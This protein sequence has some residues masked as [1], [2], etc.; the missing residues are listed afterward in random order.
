M[1]FIIIILSNDTDA[2][3]YQQDIAK[4]PCT[5]TLPGE[6]NGI[7]DGYGNSMCAPP[8]V[9]EDCSIK[10]CKNNCTFNGWCSLEYPVARYPPVKYYFEFKIKIYFMA[11]ILFI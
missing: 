9:G 4:L 1:C 2:D 6:S 11:R 7:C 3:F 10:D 8:Y 5:Q